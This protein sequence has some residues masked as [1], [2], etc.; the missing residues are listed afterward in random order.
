MTGRDKSDGVLDRTYAD[1]RR[2]KRA[3]RYRLWRRTVEVCRAFSLYG[4]KPIRDILDLGAADGRMLQSIHERFPGARC[5]GVE[6]DAGL[7]A[8]ASSLP[9]IE[10]SR[11]DI[12]ALE[13]GDASFDTVS[14]AAVIEHVRDPAKAVAEAARVLRPGGIFV[15]TSPSPFWEALATRLGH[16]KNDQHNEV[17]DLARLRRLAEDAGLEVVEAEKFMLSPVGM[18]LEF[19]TERVLRALGLRCLMANQL[20]AARRPT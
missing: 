5:A 10:I 13:F 18:P 11:G 1:D 12:Q 4:P 2:Q 7:A 20:I 9:D 3:P 6:Y 16:L 15:M 19:Q 8:L 14:A 17:M